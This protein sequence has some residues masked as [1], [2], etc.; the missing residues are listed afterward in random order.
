M[1]G[2]PLPLGDGLLSL[3]KVDAPLVR[4]KVRL[5]ADDNDLRLGRIVA[6]LADPVFEVV[7]AVPASDVVHKHSEERGPVVKFGCEAEDQSQLDRSGTETLPARRLL[8]HSPEA[9]LS[10]S[11]PDLKVNFVAVDDEPFDE[12][13]GADCRRWRHPLPIDVSLQERRLANA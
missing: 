4:R 7:E 10:S 13:A 9:F 8:T 3:G 12:K 11:V 6:N 1:V 2:L 5:G